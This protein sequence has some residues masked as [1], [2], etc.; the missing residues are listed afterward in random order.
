VTIDDDRATRTDRWYYV[1]IHA[2]LR[3]GADRDDAVVSAP[4]AEHGTPESEWTQCRFP[5]RLIFSGAGEVR[6]WQ[7]GFV[8]Q[9]PPDETA[10]RVE[11]MRRFD[12][13]VIEPITGYVVPTIVLGRET[14][15]WTVRV[16]GGQ[17]GPSLSDRYRDAARERPGDA[18]RDSP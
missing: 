4:A 7:R 15:R 17:H 13:A 3:P 1:D 16:H 18:P 10:A 12:A 2:A 6:R 11:L 8:E 5:L 14:S 9:A